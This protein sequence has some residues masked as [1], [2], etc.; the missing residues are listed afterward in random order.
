[1]SQKKKQ[2]VRTAAPQHLKWT[3]GKLSL[4]VPC[5]NEA[6]RIPQMVAALK[7][8]DRWFSPN[9][10]EVI[11]V[12]D[13]STDG[14][15]Q[16]CQER[17]GKGL[18]A[19]VHCIANP[20][21]GGKGSALQR[22]V[23]A[24]TGDCI[25]T[26]D[27]DMASEPMELKKWVDHFPNGAPDGNTIYI[28]S[29]EHRDSEVN[30]QPLRRVSGL[31]FNFIVQMLTGL[32]FADTQCG[33]KLYPAALAK[34]LFA[35]LKNKGWAHD[36][37]L[38]YSAELQGAAIE[39]LPVKWEEKGGSKIK[40]LSDSFK[41]FF[42]TLGISLRLNFQHFILTPIKEL[43]A[44]TWHW[45]DP[46]YYR[47]AFVALS[48]FLMVF[49]PMVSSD[50]GITGDEEVQ[51]EYGEKVL[52]Y[53]ETDGK[54]KAALEYKNLYYYGGLFDY[55][56]AWA[57]KHIGGMDVYDMR[58]LINAFV[59]F[60]MM[61]FT[62]LVAREVSGQWRVAFFALLFMALSPRLFGHSMNNPKDIP[63]AAACIF[64]TLHLLRF[65]RQLPFLSSKTLIMIGLGIALAINV[66]VGG[67][68]LVA[69]FGL[70][71]LAGFWWK[72]KEVLESLKKP[73]YFFKTLAACALVAVLG[74]FAG[75]LWWPYG[76][77]SPI[78]H[79]MKAL[80]EM[81][82]FS[83]GIRMLFEGTHY[84]SDALPWYYAPK[85]FLIASPL[86]VLVGWVLALVGIAFKARKDRDMLLLL[87]LLAFTALFPM[88]YA[89]YK[90]SA[91]YDGIRHFLFVYPALA[92]IAACG[93]AFAMNYFNNFNFNK[94]YKIALSVVLAAL[95]YLPLSFMLRN[96]PYEYVYFNETVGGIKGAYANYETD[97]W[98]VSTKKMSEWLAAHD[99]RVGRGE[100]VAVKTNA[101]SAAKHYLITG[102]GIKDNQ[103]NVGYY[104][105]AKR[106]EQHSDY[107]MFV[108][109]FVD[110]NLMLNGVWPPPKVLHTE[111]VDGV[112]IGSVSERGV[113]YD[114]QAFM[115]E[116]DKNFPKA[117]SL[118]RLAVA[119]NPKNEAALL[120]AGRARLQ[121]GDLPTAKQY[122]DASLKLSD[123][124]LSN[125]LML[126]YYYQMAKDADNAIATYEKVAAL[127][128]K[129]QSAQMFLAQLY[130][131]K[132]E[133]Q[134]AMQ[135]LENFG[136]LGGDNAQLFTMG[137]QLAT[138]ASDNVRLYYFKAKL[139]LAQRNGPATVQNLDTALRYNPQHKPSLE[140]KRQVEEA[141]AASR[142]AQGKQ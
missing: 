111:T 85:W 53:Y 16:L 2:S 112:P 64:T 1:M 14:T 137:E 121:M 123:T 36:V 139:S 129:E 24:A 125:L 37:E 8:F 126:G 41:M 40:L 114:Y 74:Y 102:A 124:Y 119:Q 140:L 32:P 98:M 81:S 50:F 96:H 75:L 95:L 113:D 34:R 28:A 77:Q 61:F 21:N 79:P 69:Y 80:A 71:G 48:L 133:A 51:K 76:A 136:Q 87:G 115:A 47:L 73:G 39:A 128:Y 44:R 104:N 78:A 142:A 26:L 49:M 127:S 83:T 101:F 13:G 7:D 19:S 86:F 72:R 10:L 110:R 33:F 63:F 132:G 65:V 43:G 68:L 52:S 92:V 70:F 88:A 59:G 94:T 131:Q 46:S 117:D 105:F 67:I 31:I 109:R 38:L 4:V 18:H 82:N 62:G 15:S 66:R 25:L 55:V 108:S 130:A 56:C 3:G 60:L 9:E 35:S 42:Q 12:D 30:G 29:R 5:Y 11:I 97:Y 89:I 99:A 91:L 84:W 22:G 58:H 106:N 135:A 116:K 90:Q 103:L 93:W 100:N 141:M 6:A 23:A 120:G 118:Y 20:K 54:D 122:F 138:Q 57:N 27:A 107:D 45:A 134:K 17:L